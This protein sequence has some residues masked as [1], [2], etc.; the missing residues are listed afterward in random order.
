MDNRWKG[1]DA[2]SVGLATAIG[3]SLAFLASASGK[4]E[5][6]GIHNWLGK[7]GL[8]VAIAVAVLF[9]RLQ[10][11]LRDIRALVRLPPKALCTVKAQAVGLSPSS[12]AKPLLDDGSAPYVARD[13][14][15]R[16][17]DLLR[18]ESFVLLV[19]PS[20]VGKTT[21][22]F[23]VLQSTCGGMPVLAPNEPGGD[24]EDGGGRGL[25]ELLKLTCRLPWR[26]R[27]YVLWIDDLGRYLDAGAISVPALVSWLE[28][29][30]KRR[31]VATLNSA[32]QARHEQAQGSAG[33]VL[34]TLMRTAE[35][36]PISAN[37]TKAEQRRAKRFY[38][39]LSKDA[40]AHLARYLAF[41]PLLKDRYRRASEDSPQAQAVVRVI[42][43][44]RRVGIT[45]VSSELVLKLLPLYLA[46][47]PAPVELE[48]ILEEALEWVAES[49]EGDTTLVLPNE[50]DSFTV[51]DI[52]VELVQQDA[53]DF[54]GGFWEALLR[55]RAG[56]WERLNLAKAALIYD[57]RDVAR[58]AADAV[59]RDE[60]TEPDLRRAAHRLWSEISAREPRNAGGA[61]RGASGETPKADPATAAAEVLSAHGFSPSP[62]RLLASVNR[63]M[64]AK[65]LLRISSLFTVD[66]ISLWLSLVGAY[67][68]LDHAGFEQARA[69][70][71]KRVAFVVLVTVLLFYIA[72]LYRPRMRRANF[73]RLL[74]ALT[75]VGFVFIILR[76]MAGGHI[77]SFTLIV[78][79]ISFAFAT[80]GLA[81][82]AHV[83]VSDRLYRAALGRVPCRVLIGTRREVEHVAALA[84]EIVGEYDTVGW[85]ST[86]ESSGKVSGIACLGSVEEIPKLIEEHLVDDLVLCGDSLGEAATT[87]IADA[88][89]NTHI[90]LWAISSGRFLV[91]ASHY[92]PG[93]QLPL[94]ELRVPVLDANQRLIKRAFDITGSLFGL[95]LCA[96]LWLLI[97]FA[98][99]VSSKGPAIQTVSREGI[100]AKPFAMF[101]F[102][103]AYVPAAA[104]GKP[105]STPIGRWLR[106][107]GL[108][109]LPQLLN[110]LLGEMSL[111]GPRPI[112]REQHEHLEEWHLRRYLVLPGLTG[113][114]QISGRH[115]CDFAD[116][117][118]LDF[119]YV[120][121]WS[122]FEDIEILLKS[123]PLSLRGKRAKMV[124]AETMPVEQGSG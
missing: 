33:R 90:S 50:G 8:A 120:Q 108:D 78:L 109:E 110:V 121:H 30:P 77:G 60:R 116:M 21:T 45:S 6:L 107:T 13:R 12:L 81:R 86:E 65:T 11:R 100:R 2:L 98:I 47:Q 88:V 4:F 61:L 118:R 105:V 18:K 53:N 10:N 44:C 5:T 97:V 39:Q 28:C 43:D 101:R 67:L 76:V 102:R 124:R 16:L 119:Y 22:L 15:W 29:N 94:D 37:W 42:A 58:D 122:L 85:L 57:R 70:A 80:L 104:G 96:P 99:R 106:H 25:T 48:Q 46:G 66:V 56:G 52:V 92:V 59:M 71:D 14:D 9:Q 73:A 3:A 38:G 54:P 79:T 1:S 23:H 89:C 114:W 35:I 117:V 83:W 115:D 36:H 41:G 69:A 95:V 24:S 34:Q 31:I 87:K 75:Q 112:E 64:Q 68:W 82:T 63:S 62:H 17:A 91:S 93:E 19:G 51:P 84:C 20:G 27:G 7:V 74:A 123:V 111:V 26:R 103:S 113:L 40:Y 32:D 55:H 49:Q 72:G